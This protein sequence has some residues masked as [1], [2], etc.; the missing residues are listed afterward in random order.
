MNEVDMSKPG[1]RIR[2]CRQEMNLTLSQLADSVEVSS[3]YLSA[4]ERGVKNPSD[5]VLHKIADLAKVSYW[6]LKAGQEESPVK[7]APLTP[8]QRPSSP[9][10]PQKPVLSLNAISANIDVP[11]FLSL[12]IQAVPSMSKEKLAIMLDASP[13]AIEKILFGEACEIPPKWKDYFSLLA[14]QMDLPAVRQKVH[15][16]DLFLQNEGSEKGQKRLF[17]LAKRYIGSV[18][19][20]FRF[21]PMPESIPSTPRILYSEHIV[22][23]KSNAPKTDDD[24]YGSWHFFFYRFDGI[25]GALVE[26]IMS[27]HISYCKECH[28]DSTLVFDED[29]I[30]DLFKQEYERQRASISPSAGR[31]YG[32]DGNS[33][34]VSLLVVDRE[35]WE[36]RGDI[37]RLEGDD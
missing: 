1:G 11:L 2:A 28:C 19:E 8:P 15:A 25:D 17:E 16:L 36:P 9:M 35:T 34:T 4:V 6:W 12:V 10:A 33:P 32:E 26:S 27:S 5:K 21:N 18:Y 13:E 31:D 7:E 29:S 24:N 3:N 14:R 22:F 37:I 23:L 20:Y 30:L